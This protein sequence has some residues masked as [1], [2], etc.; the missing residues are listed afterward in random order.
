MCVRINGRM[1]GVADKNRIILVFV[2]MP[3]QNL[4]VFVQTCQ[5]VSEQR[6]VG[7]WTS[8]QTLP[9]VKYTS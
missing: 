5:I 3:R 2:N 6:P 4:L 8:L 9:I 1:F 7:C